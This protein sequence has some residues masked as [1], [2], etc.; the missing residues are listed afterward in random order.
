MNKIGYTL[1][2][3]GRIRRFK[4]KKTNYYYLV[5]GLLAILFS[6]TH[7]LNGQHAVIPILSSNGLDINTVTTFRYIWHIITA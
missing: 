5:A 2:T 1:K 4:I 6:V 3:S 7:E